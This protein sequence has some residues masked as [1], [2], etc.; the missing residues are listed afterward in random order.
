MAKGHDLFVFITG[1]SRLQDTAAASVTLP[2]DDRL[3]SYE[4]ALGGENGRQT[5]WGPFWGFL[6]PGICNL[7]WLYIG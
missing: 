3:I 2:V 4:I 7:A 5:G 6:L 1:P